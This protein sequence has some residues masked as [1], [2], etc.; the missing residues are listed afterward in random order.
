MSTYYKHE[1]II[2]GLIPVKMVQWQNEV[3]STLWHRGVAYCDNSHVV[4]YNCVSA[5]LESW[6]CEH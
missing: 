6:E 2:W 3:E 5:F 1:Q 4:S